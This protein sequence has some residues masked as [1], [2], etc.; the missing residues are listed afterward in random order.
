M[1][2]ILLK[3]V[4]KV[5][6]KYEVKEVSDGFALNYLIPQGLAK[7]ATPGNLKALQKKIDEQ[8][9]ARSKTEEEMSAVLGDL[10]GVVVEISATANDKG[11]LFK[12]IS[13]GDVVVALA[14]GNDLTVDESILDFA[15]VK[16][17]GEHEVV[18]RVGDK[19][20]K[21]TLVVKAE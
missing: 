21:F 4:A 17:V 8:A 18:A 5:G 14:S 3:G 19:Q 1:K 10:Q 16:E 6:Q 20:T 12:A 11:T 15:G 13:A 2:V 7:E 9:A